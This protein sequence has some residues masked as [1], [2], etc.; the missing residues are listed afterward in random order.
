MTVQQVVRPIAVVVSVLLLLALAFTGITGGIDQWPNWSS[1]SHRAQSSAEVVSGLCA[2]LIPITRVTLYRLR[3]AS[4]IGFVAGSVAAAGLAPVV[5]ADAPVT[6]GLLSGIV[7][8]AIAAAIVWMFRFG[9]G[10][11]GLVNNPENLP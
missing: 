7:A 4:E 8:L 3:K 10:S 9:A 1:L 5:W 2:L 6:Q 11:F